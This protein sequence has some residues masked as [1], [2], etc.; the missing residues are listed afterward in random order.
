MP[1][2]MS[3]TR[4]RHLRGGVRY[5]ASGLFAIEP[6]IAAVS[7]YFSGHGARLC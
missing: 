7:R 4:D 5:E 1:P 6:V 3:G 2:P